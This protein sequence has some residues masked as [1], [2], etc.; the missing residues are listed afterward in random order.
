MREA[1]RV[2]NYEFMFIISPLH[3]N[4]EQVKTI[5]DHLRS[6][7]ESNE[8]E[9]LSVNSSAPWGRRRL[10]YPIRAYSGGEASRRHFTDGF[11]VLMTFSL[12]STRIRELE[13][14][15]G[16][17]DSILR[18]LITTD[19]KKEEEEESEGEESEGE[20]SEGETDKEY[21]YEDA[22]DEE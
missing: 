17:M 16:L 13:R 12:L 7:I 19:E 11:Y 1:E 18:H 20:K 6:V 21:E 5:I 9:I 3:A 22:A 4:D 14:V 8:G 10:A 2:R 15:V